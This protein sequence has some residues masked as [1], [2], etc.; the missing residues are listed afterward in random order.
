MSFDVPQ[1]LGP[2]GYAPIGGGGGKEW[3]YDVPP[4][5]GSGSSSG[6]TNLYDYWRSQMTGVPEAQRPVVPP[7]VPPMPPSYPP[8]IP[9]TI[10]G[11]GVGD[12]TV[13]VPPI[14]VNIQPP[15]PPVAP[16]PQPPAPG[17]ANPADAAAMAAGATLERKTSAFGD[18]TLLHWPD[19]TDCESWA[20]FRKECRHFQHAQ[21]V[22]NPDPVVPTPSPTPSPFPPEPGPLDIPPNPYGYN[23][24]ELKLE[25]EFLILS[26]EFVKVD[27][28]GELKLAKP[29]KN[30]SFIALVKR[31]YSPKPAG[32][33]EFLAVA[34]HPLNAKI[35]VTDKWGY[36]Q[37]IGKKGPM[38]A[39]RYRGVF[40]EPGS[41]SEQPTLAIPKEA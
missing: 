19:G 14:N 36:L 23:L 11:F 15:A 3:D 18:Y 20:H 28:Y 10:P 7:Y 35:A 24:D 32:R 30:E 27:G 13:N 29:N 33:K 34:N 5:L 6:Y 8:Y 21:P 12:V 39:P 22:P 41:G 4:G 25:Q 31:A 1:G 2:P 17:M 38:F 40:T 16:S 9:P 26:N 37:L